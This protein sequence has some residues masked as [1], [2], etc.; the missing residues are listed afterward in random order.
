M[1]FQRAIDGVRMLP[2]SL[3]H[4]NWARSNWSCNR[5]CRMVT[6]SFFRQSDYFSGFKLWDISRNGRRYAIAATYFWLS[7]DASTWRYDVTVKTFVVARPCGR[8][9][10]VIGCVAAG[11]PSSLTQAE[12]LF[13][14]WHKM[15]IQINSIQ[16]EV[17][18]QLILC[19][20]TRWW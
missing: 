14:L 8:W 13:S 1:A 9:C 11:I 4:W 18:Y 2:L 15:F 17:S 7:V 5:I 3:I 16:C 19:S 10:V 20:T 12:F 6:I